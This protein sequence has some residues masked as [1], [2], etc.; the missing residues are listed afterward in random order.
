MDAV[1]DVR[2]LARGTVHLVVPHPCRAAVLSAVHA[3]DAYADH[4]LFWILRVDRDRVE[5]HSAE[6][7]HPLSARR[8]VVEALHDRPGLAAVLALEERGRLCARPYHVGRLLVSRLDV[9]GLGEGAVRSLREG[10]VLRGL[11]RF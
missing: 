11:P 7:R 1:E 2:P 10:R 4:H 9:P 8:L 6:A 5:A 3:T